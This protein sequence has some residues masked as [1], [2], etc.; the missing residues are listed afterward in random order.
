MWGGGTTKGR[1]SFARHFSVQGYT[2]H[3][4]QIPLLPRLVR[5]MGEPQSRRAG[6]YVQTCSLALFESR[7]CFY[8]HGIWL[9][10]AAALLS[11]ADG[12]TK[13]HRGLFQMAKSSYYLEMINKKE[14]GE[15]AETDFGD[16][17]Q[18]V[19]A[20]LPRTQTKSTT[21]GKRARLGEWP[22][23]PGAPTEGHSS[24]PA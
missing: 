5:T 6:G 19:S 4:G 10:Q 13:Q 1:Q 2:E 22:R 7:V 21:W 3:K 15:G 23:A 20:T 18:S 8:K 12:S 14:E 9:A 11:A 16:R 24:P 17:R